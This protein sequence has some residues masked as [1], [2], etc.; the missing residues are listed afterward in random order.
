VSIQPKSLAGN[1]LSL[2]SAQSRVLGLLLAVLIP[3]AILA[4]GIAIWLVRR[5]Q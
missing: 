3:L 2:S 5:Y 4:A 1:T